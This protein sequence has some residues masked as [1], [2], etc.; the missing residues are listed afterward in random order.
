MEKEI[1]QTNKAPSAIGPYSQGT[2][3][4]HLV[5]SSGQVPLSPEDGSGPKGDITEQTT[6]ALEN[7]K[8]VLEAGGASLETVLK[9]TCF[10]TDMNHFAEFNAVYSQYFKAPFPARSCIAVAGLPKGCLVEVEAI[11]HIIPQR[12]WGI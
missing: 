6:L 7:L 2:T 12:G 9:T 5:F 1:I 3:F 4:H 11:A 10:L 8:A